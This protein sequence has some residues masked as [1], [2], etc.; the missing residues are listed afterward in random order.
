MT[1]HW[2]FNS[3]VVWH[4]YSSAFHES[5]LCDEANN[6]FQ[7]YHHL[8]A[9]I[10]FSI[11]CTEAFLNSIIRKKLSEDGV[12]E[13]LVLKKLRKTTL[14]QKIKNWPSEVC[15]RPVDMP[16]QIIDTFKAF[17]AVRNEVTHANNRDHSI[18]ADLDILKAYVIVDA[19]ARFIVTV[20]SAMERPFPYW[21]LGW[22]YVGFNGNAA[23]PFE[24]N[25]LN[26]FVHSLRNLNISFNN[27]GSDN[28]WE[29]RAMTTIKGFDE[30]RDILGKV[31]VDIE[32]YHGR[33]PQKP[34]LTKRWWDAE[35]AK[36]A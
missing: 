9:C 21:L 13:E 16:D 15:G 8:R 7:R 35:V 29:K 36:Y 5:V 28:E 33:F 34:R 14:E 27:F 26:G 10:Y 18:Y 31:P 4:C 2:R 22:N 11:S 23:H 24:S 25:N 30:L 20:F 17:Q 3:N 12:E 32:P 6:K 1:E 19:V